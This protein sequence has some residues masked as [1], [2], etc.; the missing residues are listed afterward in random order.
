MKHTKRA[1]SFEIGSFLDSDTSWALISEDEKEVNKEILPPNKHLLYFKK[2]KRRGKIVTLV[3][4]FYLSK[5]DVATLLKELKKSLGSG[6][7]FKDGFIEI[8]G[9]NQNRLKELLLKK[10]FRFKH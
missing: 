8:Q 4:E 7:S 5:E 3:G 9:E 6:G 1:N 10:E 2:E